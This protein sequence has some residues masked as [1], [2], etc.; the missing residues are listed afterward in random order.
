MIEQFHYATTPRY[1]FPQSLEDL[2]LPQRFIELSLRSMKKINGKIFQPSTI[3]SYELTKESPE[4][5]AL[6]FPH[7]DDLTTQSIPLKPLSED[8]TVVALDVS[9]IRIGE[10]K[11]G[12]LCAVRGAIVSREKSRYR[13]LRLGPFPFHITEEN[14]KEIC[15][16]L[17]KHYFKASGETNAYSLDNIHN[18]ICNMLERWLQMGVG[19]SS[20]RSIILWDGSLTAGSIDSPVNVVS[21]LL[22]VARNRLNAVLAFSKITRLRL[23][24]YRLTDLV[25]KCPPPSLLQINGFAAHNSGK[26]CFLGKIYVARLT[27]G[28]CSFRLDIDQ[29]ITCEQGLDAVQKLLG[30]DLFIQSYP[31]SLRLA[32]IFSTFTANEVIGIQRLIAQ[33]CGLKIVTRPNVRRLLFG[34]FGKGSEG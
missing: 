6:T 11:N 28:S 18:R 16:M 32:H 20:Y 21:K 10:T 14:K 25:W 12:V 13:C 7:S 8:I 27:E 9:S 19:S 3:A 2:Q 22:E 23:S 17:R 33:K 26:L 31:E 34:P 1:N 4:D 30:N 29:G 5:V 24:G 15:T